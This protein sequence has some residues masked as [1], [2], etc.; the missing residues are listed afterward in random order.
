MVLYT[1]DNSKFL[2]RNSTPLN[3][4]IIYGVLAHQLEHLAHA[5]RRDGRSSQT[6]T[7]NPQPNN[8][9]ALKR[10]PYNRPG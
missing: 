5:R 10:F 9:D 8:Q 7:V 3:N 2:W 4:Q 6:Q 1:E